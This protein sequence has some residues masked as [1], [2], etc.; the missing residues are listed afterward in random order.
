M[1]EQLNFLTKSGI[2][3]PGQ[4]NVKKT[5]DNLKYLVGH[6]VRHA[7]GRDLRKEDLPIIEE[8]VAESSSS[9][10]KKIVSP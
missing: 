1:N 5:Q 6:M 9:L 3:E 2:D 8:W 7:I 4:T 10:L